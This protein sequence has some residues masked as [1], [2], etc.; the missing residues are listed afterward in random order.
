MGLWIQCGNENAVFTIGWKNFAQTEKGVA[1]QVQRR[2][3]GDFFLTS[4]VLCNVNSY[5]RGKQ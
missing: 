4:R 1:G 2:S 3:H 5:V